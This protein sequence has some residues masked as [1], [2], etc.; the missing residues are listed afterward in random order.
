MTESLPKLPMHTPPM[1]LITCTKPSDLYL[2]NQLNEFN[3]DTENISATLFYKDSFNG[4][5]VVEQHSSVE[6]S[7]LIDVVDRAF[8][9]AEAT[10]QVAVYFGLVVF[11]HWYGEEDRYT[12]L[13]GDDDY[14]GVSDS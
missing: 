8:A 9:I 14:N 13:S 12:G 5:W 6:M 2:V 1:V 11:S 7:V 3:G 10:V 4:W